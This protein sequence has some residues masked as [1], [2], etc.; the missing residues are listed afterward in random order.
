MRPSIIPPT[1]VTT[2]GF[3]ITEVLKCLWV[4]EAVDIGILMP[5]TVTLATPG[6]IVVVAI[7]EVYLGHERA[8]TIYLTIVGLIILVL[9]LYM[10]LGLK[11]PTTLPLTIMEQ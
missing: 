8:E 11:I 9:M 4:M 3:M 6:F 10:E 1:I 5:A 7:V 2:I